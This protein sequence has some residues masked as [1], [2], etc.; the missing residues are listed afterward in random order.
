MASIKEIA[1]LAGVSVK[2]ASGALNDQASIRMS[3]ETRLRVIEVANQQGY[4]PSFAAQAMRLGALPLVG[5]VSDGAINSPYA[6]D[7]MRGLEKSLASERLTSITTMLRGDIEES[8]EWLEQFKPRSII[9]VSGFYRRVSIPKH[10]VGRILVLVN[11]RDADDVIPSIVAD[12]LQGGRDLTQFLIDAGHRRI[13]YVSLPGLDAST[14]RLEG[15]ATALEQAGL[16]LDPAHV[17]P[18]T[19]RARYFDGEAGSVDAPLRALL[20]AGQLPDALICGNDRVAMDVYAA[21]ARLGI[22]VSETLSV[23]SF[24]NQV[25]LARRMDP[26]LTSMALPHR[27]MGAIAGRVCA[28]KDTPAHGHT[29]AFRLVQRQSHRVRK[30]EEN[31]GI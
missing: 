3:D 5:V 21:A 4:R 14:V 19:S 28:A 15:V 27:R 13:G 8:V 30:P 6:A 1:K 29:L 16:H 24:D 25:E 7:I 18:A 31:K 17:F 9:Y 12:E 10:M 22:S 23:C 20:A 2:T 11:C 26:P